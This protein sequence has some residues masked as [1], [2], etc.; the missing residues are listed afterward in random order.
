MLFRSL[1]LLTGES[2]PQ[3]RSTGQAIASGAVNI[4]QPVVLRVEKVAKD[5]TLSSLIRLIERAGQGK[6]SIAQWADK[7]AAWFVSALLLF[8][9]GVF[10]FWSWHDAA[11]AWPIAIAVLV[12]S[13]PCALSLA[14]PSA[15]AA[16]TDRLLRQGVLV[17]QPH[18]LETLH[19]AKIGRAHV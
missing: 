4:S 3:R 2:Q 12:V 6:P 13:C 9:V 15:L 19:R 10:A 1:S 5:S 8:A 16:A 14:T 11:R 7:V 18:V 17:M